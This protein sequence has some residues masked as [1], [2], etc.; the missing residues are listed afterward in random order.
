MVGGLDRYYQ[1]ATCWRDEDL[2]ADRQFEFRQLDLEMAFVDREDVLDV[3]ERGGRRV[4]RGGRPSSAGAAVPAD[5]LRRGDAALRHR[6]ARPPLRP[7]DRGRDRADAR[8]RVRRL[9]EGAG[10]PLSRRRRGRSRAPSS[11][12]SRRS[13]RSGGR[14]GSPISSTRAARSA[15]RSRSSSPSRSSP[16]STPSP[17]RRCS[18]PPTTRRS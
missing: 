15:R 4:V 10:R 9:L 14:R 18:S 17:A 16:R 12:G 11:A 3:L 5:D 8:L 2:R 7:R 13:R 6:Q 1:I